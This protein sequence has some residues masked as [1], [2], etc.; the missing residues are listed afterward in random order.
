MQHVGRQT[1]RHDLPIMR[2]FQANNTIQ[3]GSRWRPQCSRDLRQGGLQ[4]PSKYTHFSTEARTRNLKS[5]VSRA[6]TR[7][8]WADRL[9]VPGLP[10]LPHGVEVPHKTPSFLLPLVLTNPQ[11][12]NPNQLTSATKNSPQTLSHYHP[13]F[14]L[15][16]KTS[17]P[18]LHPIPWWIQ[19]L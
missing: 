14:T 11:Y 12:H 18:I 13:S 10:T 9:A 8:S 19:P 3:R 5:T 2:L 4:S 15:L 17:L 16:Y 6:E 1:D 7:I